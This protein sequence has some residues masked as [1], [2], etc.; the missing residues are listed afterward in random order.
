MNKMYSTLHCKQMAN[1][2]I[3]PTNANSKKI[4]LRVLDHRLYDKAIKEKRNFKREKTKLNR[5]MK[6]L[7]DL[8][9]QSIF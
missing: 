6:L 2:E 4:H 1:D 5:Q 7:F 3:Y 9:I 8:Q